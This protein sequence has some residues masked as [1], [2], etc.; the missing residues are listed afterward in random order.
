MTFLQDHKV[1]FDAKDVVAHPEYMEELLA[2][3]GGVRGTPVIVIDDKVYRGFDRGLI[4]RALDL[5]GGGPA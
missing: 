1:P 3:T 4:A 2:R 5:H